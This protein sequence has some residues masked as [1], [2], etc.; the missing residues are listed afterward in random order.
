MSVA[1]ILSRSS[2]VGTITLARL[3]GARRLSEWIERWG[4]GRPTGIDFPGESRGIVLPLER[5]SGS[6]I[7][8]VP[9]GQGIAVTP[10]QMA[11]AYAAVASGGVYV[12]PHLVAHVEGGARTK[13][14]RRRIVSREVA[15]RL[16]EMLQG[17]VNDGGTG[18]AARVEGYHVAGKTGT[19]AKPKRG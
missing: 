1:Q 6:T 10:V 2:N 12:Q 16:A 4:F 17:V 14:K 15:A 9:L 3:L 7:G 5:W 18:T 8:N 19:A 11:A 13:P